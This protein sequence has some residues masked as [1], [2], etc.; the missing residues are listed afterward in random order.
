[1][2]KSKALYLFPVFRAYRIKVDMK[3]IYFLPLGLILLTFS[4]SAQIRAPR[5][6]APQTTTPADSNAPAGK[7]AALQARRG[8]QPASANNTATAARRPAIVVLSAPS[9]VEHLNATTPRAASISEHARTEAMR[10]RMFSSEGDVYAKSLR[11]SKAPLV[12]QMQGRGIEVVSQAE[13]VL[14]AV[15]IGATEEDLAWLRTQPG[16]QSAEF[17]AIRHLH[18]NAATS[19]IGANTVWNQIGGSANAGKGVMIAILDSGIDINHPM[20]SGSGFSLPTGKQQFPLTNASTGGTYT[21]NK[22]IVAKNYVCPTTSGSCPNSSTSPN[23]STFDH[24]ASDAFGHGTGV[25]SAAA[26]V[27]VNN[28]PLG[29]GICGVAPGA[30]LANYKV[31]DSTG[32]GADAAFLQAMNDAVADG[33]NII[34]YSGGGDATGELPNQS[35][36]YTAIHNAVQ[37][38]V[39]VVISAGNCGPFGESGCT[40]LGDNTIQDP[41]IVPDAITPGGSSNS[42]T[43]ANSLTITSSV[44]VP[45]NLQSLPSLTAS[46]PTFTSVGPA[47]IADVLPLD[48]TGFACSTLPAGSLSG[49]IAL[50]RFSYD[51]PCDPNAPDITKINN[52]QAAGAIGVIMIDNLEEEI[53]G[54]YNYLSGA[55]IPATLITYVDGAN[56][57]AF[58]DAN[59]GG[60]KALIN[61]AFTLTP[62]VPDQVVDY[63]S[64]GP[65][66]DFTIKPDLLA[67]ADMLVA[68]QRTNP[69]PNNAIYDPSGYLY[70]E[71][72]SYSAP[73]TSGAAAILK[74]QRPTLTAHD[75]KSALS[76]TGSPVTSTQD[77]AVVSVQMT[78]GGRLNLPAALATTLVSDPVSISFGQLASAASG[79][80]ASQSVTLKNVGTASETFAVTVNQAAS[81][82]GLSVTAPATVSLAAGA[83][84]TLTVSMKLTAAVYGIY[85]GTIGLQSQSSATSIHIPYWMMLGTPNIPAGSLVDGAGFGK[86]VSP[87]DIVSLFG[88][89]LGTA[90]MGAPVI[91]LP[92]DINHTV[93]TVTGRYTGY[94][95]TQEFS[96]PLFYSSSGQVN[97]QVPFLLVSGRNATVQVY[98]QGIVGNALTFQPTATAPGIFTTGSGAA[99]VTDAITGAM[100][101]ASNPATAGQILT[102]YCAGLGATNPFVYDGDPGIVP[103]AVTTA[104]PTVSIGGKAATVNFS[105][106]TPL[107]AGLYQINATVAAGTPTGSQPISIS[108][109]GATSNAPTTYIH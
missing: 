99:I 1:V 109:G 39:M 35:T 92:F 8:R 76:N 67:P 7:R 25:A 89:G 2:A 95:G 42:H 58:V 30:Y 105:G 77:G 57:Q 18:L 28:T 37:A 79:T 47:V 4:T 59:P 12:S 97:F 3:R 10:Q 106:L 21:N 60:V 38:G 16:V 48:G 68:S 9:L 31:F 62:Q 34:N 32:S 75:I 83:T 102:I 84:T 88:T 70:S 23:G 22:V 40:V 69:D 85:E 61:G 14:N 74:Q 11:D 5:T 86:T 54:P 94:S 101:T 107:F 46:T 56:L 20:F 43:E 45:A 51:A 13:H 63:S 98:L 33:M 90:G 91:P 81:N 80:T 103:P 66:N 65:L 87:G 73:I 17:S 26:G 93:V 71:G 41:G 55:N 72:T 29:A 44:V 15:M 50:I 27:C 19:L 108:I 64:R 52:A 82:A 100:I 78:G 53:F 36:D 6:A 24:N 49:K 104:N 96:A